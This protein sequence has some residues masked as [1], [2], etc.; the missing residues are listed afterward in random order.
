MS[1]HRSLQSPVT[2]QQWT[3]M[4]FSIGGWMTNTSMF[5]SRSSSCQMRT[6]ASSAGAWI[7]RSL[8]VC[9]QLFCRRSLQSWDSFRC[10]NRMESHHVSAVRTSKAKQPPLRTSILVF[11]ISSGLSSVQSLSFKAL[12]IWMHHLWVTEC[13]NYLFTDTLL[14]ICSRLQFR[15]RGL[16]LALDLIPAFLPCRLTNSSFL[17]LLNVL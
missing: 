3:F 13:R 4:M 6:R 16:S 1:R 15:F 5:V 8:T 10:R 14:S 11:T 9:W 17:L 2:A 12:K 7:S